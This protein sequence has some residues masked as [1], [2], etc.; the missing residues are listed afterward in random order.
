MG[1]I[2][3]TTCIPYPTSLRCQF[4][5]RIFT[6]RQDNVEGRWKEVI[7]NGICHFL[8]SPKSQQTLCERFCLL[9]QKKFL[10]NLRAPHK[11]QQNRPSISHQPENVKKRWSRVDISKFPISGK[12]CLLAHRKVVRTEHQ[13]I[14]IFSQNMAISWGNMVGA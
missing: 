9:I 6:L 12:L 7:L 5:L 11:V 3:L 2:L 4:C 14:H 1:N 8:H 10:C 13:H